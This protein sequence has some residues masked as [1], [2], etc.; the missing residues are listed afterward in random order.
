VERAVEETVAKFGR[1]DYAAYA[2][3]NLQPSSSISNARNSTKAKL[4][5][6]SRNFAGV[7][8]PGERISD[9]ELKDWEKV[10]AVNT[11]GVFLCNKY[12]LRQMAKQESI[13]V[14]AVDSFLFLSSQR[15]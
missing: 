6:S 13:E 2:L 4:T 10:M 3:N 8:G 5:T 1:I 15:N 9:I 7:I 12:Q 11:T 14:Y